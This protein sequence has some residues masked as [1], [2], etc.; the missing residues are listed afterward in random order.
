MRSF[1]R[2]CIG[3][4][5]PGPE[6]LCVSARSGN[7]SLK[8]MEKHRWIL[9]SSLTQLDRLS[10]RLVWDSVKWKL[11]FRKEWVRQEKR[12]QL[13]G[14]HNNT[15]SYQWGLHREVTAVKRVL[16]YQWPSQILVLLFTLVTFG[17][18]TW[19]LCF[20]ISSL[21]HWNNNNCRGVWRLNELK[22]LMYLYQQMLNRC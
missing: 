10:E 21:R 20:S 8:V 4:R 2:H 5:W 15:R 7:S 16:H 3:Q 12:N 11:E 22:Y 17:T 19:L 14:F 9:S 18:L 1:R 13:K 6:G